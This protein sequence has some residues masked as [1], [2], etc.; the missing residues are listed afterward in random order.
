[1]ARYVPA[2]KSLDQLEKQLDYK[3]RDGK[4]LRQAVTHRSAHKDHYERLEFL[5]DSLLNHFAAD[6]LYHHMRQVPEGQLSRLRAQVVKGETLAKIAQD[7]NLADYLVLGSGEAKSGGYYKKSILADVV[8]AIIAAL[9]LDGGMDVA[10][11][12]TLKVLKAHLQALKPQTNVKDAKT[13]LQEWLQAHKYPLPEYEL[14]KAT[15]QDHQLEF[16][17]A[18]HIAPFDKPF[19]ATDSS[20]KKAEQKTAQMALEA[21]EVKNG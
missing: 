21:L 20:R 10:R 16:T 8:E 14:Q 15:G 11:N 7:L 3:F 19:V 2:K 18:C 17:V 4:L 13:R 12:W 9:Y 5:G 6:Y 1:M